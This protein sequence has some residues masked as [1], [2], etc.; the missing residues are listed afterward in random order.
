MTGLE[1]QTEDAGLPKLDQVIE[2]D[3]SGKALCHIHEVFRQVDSGDPAGMFR[4]TVA[5]GTARPLPTSSKCKFGRN[6]I[7]AA[8]SCVETI[9]PTWNSSSGAKSAG[10]RI[11]R[12]RPACCSARKTSPRAVPGCNASQLGHPNSCASHETKGHWAATCGLYRS[13]EDSQEK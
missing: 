10:L 2:F 3:D 12:S 6:S 9:P 13:G 1:G 7:W 11:S 8:S 4:G 5:G